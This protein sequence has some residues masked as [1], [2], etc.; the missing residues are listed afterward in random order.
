MEALSFIAAGLLAAARKIEADSRTAANIN[1]FY[2]L[3]EARR[4]N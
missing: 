4:E 1:I 3:F 2:V